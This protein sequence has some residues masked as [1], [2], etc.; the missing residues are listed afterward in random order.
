MSNFTNTS[1]TMGG[2]QAVLDALIAH[3]L[4]EFKDDT[5]KILGHYA[6][7]KNSALTSVELPSVTT[8]GQYA[9]QDCTALTTAIFAGLK[10]LGLDMFK[11]CTSLTNLSFPA[12]TATDQFAFQNCV[13]LQSIEFPSAVTDFANA[14]FAG[15]TSLKT[16]TAPGL[17]RLNASCFE[18]C[19]SLEINS[20]P[21][22]TYVGSYVF[23]DV[24]VDVVSLPACTS[25]GM[26]LA[27]GTGP[28]GFDFTEKLTISTNAFNGSGNMVHL[29]LRSNELCP[30]SDV[31]AFTGTPISIGCGYIYV[32]ADLVDTYKAATNWSTYADQIVS[33]SEYPK[34]STGSITDT[35]EQIFEAEQNGTY[36][37]K[38]SIGDTKIVNIDGTNVLMQIVAMDTDI[39]T[40]DTT[41][42][43][44]ITWISVGFIENRAMNSTNTTAGGWV[45]S[46]M[47][48]YMRETLF[49]KIEQ[50]VRSNIKIVN[51][52]YKS[53]TPTNG[54]LTVADTVWIPSSREIFGDTSYEDSGPVYSSFFN[55]NSSR[56][57]RDGNYGLN[58]SNNWWLRSSNSS[59]SFGSVNT[60]GNQS[61]GTSTTNTYGLVLGFCT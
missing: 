13:G 11:G 31:N 22:V 34:T 50:K 6:F 16:V 30:L 36:S 24:P 47:R 29:V 23:R 3:N 26:Y 41:K 46:E 32:P 8:V 58:L 45:G 17:T 19:T 10:T 12:L 33:L 49:P 28:T 37:S 52:T 38:Y 14:L 5:I 27:Y 40:N 56:I 1:D 7:Y 21:D 43:A 60:S 61:N 55:T 25:I 42:T 51:K 15:C 57:K 44:P 48:T 4:A 9:F 35:W 39:L 59:L 20:F 53:V 54:V 18:R 2:E